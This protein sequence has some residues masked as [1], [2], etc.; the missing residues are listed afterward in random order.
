M[1][2]RAEENVAPLEPQLKELAADL[3]GVD[4][5]DARA[6]GPDRVAEKLEGGRRPKRGRSGRRRRGAGSSNCK[7]RNI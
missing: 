4:F 7:R 2:A 3:P 6:K 5:S 1:I